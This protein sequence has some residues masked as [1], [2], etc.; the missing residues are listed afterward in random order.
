MNRRKT[1]F[2][3]LVGMVY[4]S[5]KDGVVFEPTDEFCIGDELHHEAV[6]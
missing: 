1:A 2:I 5:Q 6:L 4:L 3:S